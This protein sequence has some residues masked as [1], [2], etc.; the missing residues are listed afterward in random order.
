MFKK[1]FVIVLFILAAASYVGAI[2]FKDLKATDPAYPAVMNMVDVYRAIAGYPDGTFKG[3][4]GITRAEF[5]KTMT[6]SLDYLEQKYQKPL[7]EEPAKKEAAFKDLKTTHWAYPFVAT[8]VSKYN[9]VSGYPDGTFQPARN[10]S[11]YELAS[12]LGKTIKLIYGSYNLT[13]PK[14]EALE[15][16]DVKSNHWAAQDVL[17]LS[18]YDILPGESKKLFGEKITPPALR[19]WW[20]LTRSSASP[21]KR[22]RLEASRRRKSPR[23]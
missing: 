23:S 20:Q 6:N 9:L 2:E 5:S 14:L 17:L 21:K 10:I 18:H 7:A 8:L 1:S 11:R 3:S 16:N 22:W 4:R 19:W 12:L 15:Y 13:V